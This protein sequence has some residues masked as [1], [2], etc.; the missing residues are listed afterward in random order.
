VSLNSIDT[1]VE[2]NM[3]AAA[4]AAAAVNNAQE[5]QQNNQPA[6]AGPTAS[7]CT[8]FGMV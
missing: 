6:A 3:A 4:A 7:V 8:D 5:K 2:L 1:L